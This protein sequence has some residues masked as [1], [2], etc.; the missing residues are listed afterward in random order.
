M[1]EL[2]G[3]I[4]RSKAGRDK[5]RYFIILK[6]FDEEYVTIADGDLRMIECPKKKKLKHLMFTDDYLYQNGVK[7][8]GNENIGNSKLRRYLKQY[9]EQLENRQV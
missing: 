9:V 1:K 3:R 7:I 8:I 6:C 2:L 4:V 5:D